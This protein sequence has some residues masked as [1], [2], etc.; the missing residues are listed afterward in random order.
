[1]S[2]LRPLVGPTH[3]LA[4]AGGAV[5]GRGDGLYPGR[6]VGLATLCARSMTVRSHSLVSHAQDLA[7]VQAVVAGDSGA[8]ARL[9]DRMACVGRMVAARHR[10]LGAPLDDAALRDVVGDT[11]TRVWQKLAD[12]RGLSA[13]E[14][15]VFVFCE[16]ELRN[17]VRRWR[18]RRER[19]TSMSDDLDDVIQ[20]SQVALP[21][22][23]IHHCLQKL[24]D[25]DQCVMRSKHFDGFTLEQIA[26]R[27][28]MNLN[29]VKSRYTRALQQLK[30]C[31]LRREAGGA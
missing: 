4:D 23:D 8:R 27:L 30:Q 19:E 28:K 25:F 16:G 15:W 2:E 12:Y 20:A 7:L 11:V 18:R 3:A 22:E 21:A 1:M 31:L 10:E 14:S 24:V 9:A 29:T 13:F 26:G 17:S 6:N 5:A